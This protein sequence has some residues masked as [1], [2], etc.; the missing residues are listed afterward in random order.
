MNFSLSQGQEVSPAWCHP[1][2]EANS[3]NRSRCCWHVAPGP[4]SP[5][6]ATAYLPTSLPHLQ[7]IDP[8]HLLT[9]GEDVLLA[10]M[11]SHLMNLGGSY[12]HGTAESP[13]PG[14]VRSS[15]LMRS[16]APRSLLGGDAQ[17]EWVFPHPH[18]LPL[19]HLHP[20]LNTVSQ[21]VP[22]KTYLSPPL[23]QRKLQG[24]EGHPTQNILLPPWGQCASCVLQH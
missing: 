17:G 12:R 8:K 21:P 7:V 14:V 4:A 11:P 13:M 24:L 9:C 20:F 15:R 16:H 6:G 22:R 1:C 19:S 2:G 3:V 23:V 10:C 5:T 18:H